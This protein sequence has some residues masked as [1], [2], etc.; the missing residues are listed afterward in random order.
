MADKVDF[1]ELFE[2]VKLP[3][4]LLVVW[5]LLAFVSFILSGFNRLQMVFVPTL[6]FL[7]IGWRAIKKGLTIKQ[8]LLSGFLAGLVLSILMFVLGIVLWALGFV[9]QIIVSNAF[10]NALGGTIQAAITGATNNI[11]GTG[12]A[13]IRV[14]IGIL[15]MTPAYG[16]FTSMLGAVIAS[17]SE[18]KEIKLPSKP[19]KKENIKNETL[20]EVTPG[21]MRKKKPPLPKKKD[22]EETLGKMIKER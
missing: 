8:A 3:L 5:E 15:V 22:K 19:K 21:P 14:I 17:E 9:L 13:V 7:W 18:G 20:N 6:I 2:S 4:I 1:K 16:A 12:I 10:R 11:I